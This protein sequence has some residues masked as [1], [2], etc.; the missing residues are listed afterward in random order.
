MESVQIIMRIARVYNSNDSP[1]ECPELWPAIQTN[2]KTCNQLKEDIK[3]R[4]HA[5]S[6]D[7]SI[8]IKVGE[9]WVDD[10]ILLGTL[11]A[12]GDLYVQILEAEKKKYMFWNDLIKSFSTVFKRDRVHSK[13]D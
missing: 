8:V 12:F 1:F 6:D 9:L 2:A 13:L 4:R 5:N 11:P 10:V 3:K 7:F